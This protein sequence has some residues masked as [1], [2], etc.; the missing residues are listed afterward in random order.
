MM[1][2]VIT[3]PPYNKQKNNIISRQKEKFMSNKARKFN[4]VKSVTDT[5][6]LFILK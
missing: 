6:F 3:R 1:N 2:L 4:Y 5:S